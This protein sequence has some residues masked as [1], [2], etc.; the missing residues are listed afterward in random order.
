[1]GRGAT[2]VEMTVTCRHRSLARGAVAASSTCWDKVAVENTAPEAPARAPTAGTAAT[3]AT[4]SVVIG[5][6]VAVKTWT[7][8]VLV[9][10]ATRP[11]TG[12]PEANTQ[13][14]DVEAGG[15]DQTTTTWARAW[16]WSKTG[17]DEGDTRMT[18][19]LNSP[20]GTG[21]LRGTQS[22]KPRGGFLLLGKTLKISSSMNSLAF[23]GA[24]PRNR[25][26]SDSSS[27]INRSL[28]TDCK[29]ENGRSPQCGAWPGLVVNR[30][31]HREGRLLH[32]LVQ[33]LRGVQMKHSKPRKSRRRWLSA[34]SRHRPR[35][36]S[37]SPLGRSVLNAV[38]RYLLPVVTSV[39]RKLAKTLVSEDTSGRHAESP[40]PRVP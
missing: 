14:G 38:G 5:R 1:M 3:S 22:R 6:S 19:S 23:A 13:Q 15:L 25:P 32:L 34:V 37:Q 36:G 27:M 11:E 21:S 12:E 17:I 35:F 20:L 18:R 7:T 28:F 2:A 8:V 10:G 29:K 24:S 4:G 40:E 16:M 30:R 26:L 31:R 33:R 39:H 9:Q